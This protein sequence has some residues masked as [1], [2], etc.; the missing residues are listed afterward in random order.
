MTYNNKET[1]SFAKAHPDAKIP[2]KRSEDTA[3]DLYACFDEDYVLIKS[4]TSQLIPT[5]LISAFNKGYGLIF[6]ERGSSGTKNLKVNAGVI[7]S[8]FRGNIFVCL[9]NANDYDVV[10]AKKEI[11]ECYPWLMHMKSDGRLYPYEKAI[12]QALLIEVPEVEVI[13]LTKEEIMQIESERGTGMIGSS[14]K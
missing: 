3:Y 6:Y 9:F 13:E 11:I 14:N 12:A 8:G 5:G 4:H 1:I 2:S 10:I 7:D